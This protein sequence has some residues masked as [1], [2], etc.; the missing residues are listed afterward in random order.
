MEGI[1]VA[2][3]NALFDLSLEEKDDKKVLTQLLGMKESLSENKEFLRILDSKNISKDDKKDM[4]VSIFSKS[5]DKNVLN[6]LKLLVDKSRIKYLIGIIDAYKSAYYNHYGIKELII[7]STHAL[8]DKEIKELKQALED[9]YQEKYEAVNLIDESLIAG[10]KVQ[11]NDLVLDGSVSNK[12]DRLK[13][14]ILSK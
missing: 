4:L 1:S 13:S 10:I 3:A 11:I 9:K 5:V 7:Y 2:Y 6:F 8:S 14:T 12:L